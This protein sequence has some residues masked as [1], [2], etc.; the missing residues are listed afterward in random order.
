MCLLDFCLRHQAIAIGGLAGSE[1]KVC[2]RV[3]LVAEGTMENRD[4]SNERH[5]ENGRI[6]LAE[7]VAED[8]KTRGMDRKGEVLAA[9][10]SG[11]W[12]NPISGYGVI[13]DK[14]SRGRSSGRNCGIASS[15]RPQAGHS[16]TIQPRSWAGL[17]CACHSRWGQIIFDA[18]PSF[19]PS[20][21]ICRVQITGAPTRLFLPSCLAISF[22]SFIS[23]VSNRASTRYCGREIW[24]RKRAGDRR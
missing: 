12:W 10:P 15:C 23:K 11:P 24:C 4:G 1:A 17:S 18:K 20:P 19:C 21:Q 3:T 14:E 2:L 16:S 8:R 6:A 9:N 5:G 13:N 22:S 7:A